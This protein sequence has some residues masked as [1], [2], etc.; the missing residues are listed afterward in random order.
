MRRTDVPRELLLIRNRLL[1][2]AAHAITSSWFHGRADNVCGVPPS[3]GR[4]RTSPAFKSKT[5]SA[6]RLPSGERSQLLM[7]ES[8]DTLINS[9]V[10]PRMGSK[11][12]KITLFS[13]T[14]ARTQGLPPYGGQRK[15]GKPTKLGAGLMA[16][17]P[18][19][20]LK[21]I[22][23]SAGL[24]ASAMRINFPESGSA[25]PAGLVHCM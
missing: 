2:S 6:T 13:R 8:F 20:P 19:Y 7:S 22:T 9:L 4:M 3:S 16:L 17:I 14:S 1:P 23:G 25:L 18:E 10:R 5:E 11:A 24:P 21:S 15:L 12:V